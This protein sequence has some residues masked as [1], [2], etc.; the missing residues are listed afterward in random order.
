MRSFRPGVFVQAYNAQIAV[1]ADSHVIVAAAVTQQEHDRQQRV[2]MAEAV[3]RS[4][5]RKTKIITADKGIGG[6]NPFE[7]QALERMS[8]LVPPDGS[9]T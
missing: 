4:M 8:M 7:H 2:P 6:Q 9:R 3:R 5:G 1:D